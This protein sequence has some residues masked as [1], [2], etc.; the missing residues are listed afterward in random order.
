MMLKLATARAENLT[1]S[2][3]AELVTSCGQKNI[4]VA[5]ELLRG[6]ARTSRS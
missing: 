3:A 4:S 1:L 2:A 5:S 6:R